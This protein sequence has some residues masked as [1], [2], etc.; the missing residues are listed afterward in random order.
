MFAVFCGVAASMHC[1]SRAE[2]FYTAVLIAQSRDH[3]LQSTFGIAIIRNC[4]L[5]STNLWYY[6]SSACTQ[7]G[8][9]YANIHV[10]ARLRKKD[11][12]HLDVSKRAIANGGY[13]S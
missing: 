3:T 6:L 7:V 9:G 4:M 1:N 11:M 12:P 5:N 13:L 2:Q 8:L 10:D